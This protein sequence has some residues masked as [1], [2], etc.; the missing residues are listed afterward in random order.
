MEENISFEFK[1]N[2]LV[3]IETAYKF[4]PENFSI[5]PV[6]SGYFAADQSYISAWES[7]ARQELKNA[8]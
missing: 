8:L 7:S 4:S 3:S 6:L 2:A 1:L 5:G